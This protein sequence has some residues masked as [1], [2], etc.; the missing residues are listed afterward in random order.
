[1]L[2]VKYNSSKIYTIIGSYRNGNPYSIYFIYPKDESPFIIKGGANDLEKW[3]E[4]YKTPA[5][6]HIT[7]WKHGFSRRVIQIIN[8]DRNIY[9]YKKKGKW[10]VSLNGE[11]IKTIKRIPRKWMKELNP[12]VK[13]HDENYLD[14]KDKVSIAKHINNGMKIR[15][16]KE[17]RIQTGIGLR[18]AKHYIERYLPNGFSQNKSYLYDKAMRFLNDHQHSKIPLNQIP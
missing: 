8:V 7:Y 10:L 1:M 9:T 14:L 12:F 5:I 11:V 18:E 13:N 6:V 2:P 16:I 17:I 3:I 4:R 15:A